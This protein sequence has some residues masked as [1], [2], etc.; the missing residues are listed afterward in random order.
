LY[1]FNGDLISGHVAVRRMVKLFGPDYP[2]ISINPHGLRG[3]L[4]PPS[5]EQMAADRLPLILERQASGPFLLGGKC[6]GAMVAFEAA[7]LL[8]A[9]G[10]KVHMVAMVDPPTVNA[11]LASRAIIG[12]MKPIVSPYRLRWIYE[13]MVRLETFFKMSTSE[14][15]ARL[16]QF[17]EWIAR[18][19]DGLSH[20]NDEIPPALWDAY[21]IAMAQY[22]PAPLDEVPVIFYAADHEGRAWRHLS[23]QVEV[24]E[25]PGGHHGCLTIGAELLVDHLRQRLLACG[26][27]PSAQGSAPFRLGH[28]RPP[29][30]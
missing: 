11:R 6:N 9:A 15:M 28:S 26:C 10:H 30:R 22:L 24:V 1:F 13:L 18:R 25:V 3:E 23:S 7:R 17:P 19:H 27:E 8:M 5:I 2:I 12:V 16:K 4:I 20:P 29:P 21:S 14:R